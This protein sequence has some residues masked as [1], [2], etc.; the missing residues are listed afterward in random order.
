MILIK[1]IISWDELYDV[2]PITPEREE[3]GASGKMMMAHKDLAQQSNPLI[4][5]F[6]G[7]SL[8]ALLWYNLNI[9]GQI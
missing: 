5:L 7:A 4:K 9:N 3:N 1:L 8:S 2:Y 6:A